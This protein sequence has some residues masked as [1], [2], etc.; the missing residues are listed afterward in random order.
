M[1]FIFLCCYLTCLTQLMLCHNFFHSPAVPSKKMDR[2]FS[3]S[4][5]H[6]QRL[7]KTIKILIRKNDTS[8][9]LNLAPP[10]YKLHFYC[11][12]GNFSLWFKCQHSHHTNDMVCITAKCYNLPL[13]AKN[14]NAT[15]TPVSSNL[16]FINP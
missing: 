7:R 14:A 11:Y 15:A 12:T 16:R 1:I 6:V 10:T 4:P 13:S 5:K 2:G 8:H 3:I 9:N